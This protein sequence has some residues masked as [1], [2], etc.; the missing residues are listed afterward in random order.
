MSWNWIFLHSTG[1]L[2][3]QQCDNN[4][5]FCNLFYG[6]KAP[7]HVKMSHNLHE[8]VIGQALVGADE[9]RLT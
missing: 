2:N 9:L 6:G 4:S 8:H 5:S 7:L 1:I 3:P